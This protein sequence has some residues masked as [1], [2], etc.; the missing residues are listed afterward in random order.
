MG[1]EVAAAEAADVA[2]SYAKQ[3]RELTKSVS[4]APTE[5]GWRKLR[6]TFAGVQRWHVKL[7]QAVGRIAQPPEPLVVA[8]LDLTVAM[9]EARATLGQLSPQFRDRVQPGAAHPLGDIAG[10]R[11]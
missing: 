7:Q 9:T 11:R 1:D 3:L 4:D 2:R 10:W 6:R 5:P 8:Y